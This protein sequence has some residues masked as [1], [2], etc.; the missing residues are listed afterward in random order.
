MESAEQEAE[1]PQNSSGNKEEQRAAKV[2][3]RVFMGFVEA[4]VS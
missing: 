1:V 4:L 3:I 2:I